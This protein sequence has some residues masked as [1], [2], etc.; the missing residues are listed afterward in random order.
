VRGLGAA[1]LVLAGACVA[2][3]PGPPA[4]ALSPVPRQDRPL[5]REQV[6]ALTEGA[7]DVERAIQELE[8]RRFAFPLDAANVEAF[9]AAGAPPE[10][11]LYLKLRANAEWRAR[12]A[13]DETSARE[14]GFRG[15]GG[16]STRTSMTT[17]GR[18]GAS[19]WFFGSV[20]E[21]VLRHTSCPLL[22]VRTGGPE[23]GREGTS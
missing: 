7:P 8:E 10:V 14:A 11:V 2:P 1:F 9:R 22:V 3:P 13:A 20:A 15:P 18:T 17:H 6:L 4:G 5:T 23:S 12:V 16:R 21:N 19:R